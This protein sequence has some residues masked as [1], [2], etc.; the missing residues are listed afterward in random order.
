MSSYLLSSYEDDPIP[1]EV[2]SKADEFRASVNQLLELFD[3]SNRST[4]R[5]KVV[6]SLFSLVAARLLTYLHLC[7]Q[8]LVDS[9]PDQRLPDL[10][11]SI[12]K[13]SFEEKLEVLDAIDLPD[14][15]KVAQALIQRQISVSKAHNII[16]CVWVNLLHS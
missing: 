16:W 2:K 9:V 14:R 7:I 15:F 8:R 1:V 6:T 4:I 12:V 10:F 3:L 5:L 13:S 11:S